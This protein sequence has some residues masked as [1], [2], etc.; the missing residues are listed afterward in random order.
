MPIQASLILVILLSCTYYLPLRLK[1]GLKALWNTVLGFTI[2]TGGGVGI[3]NELRVLKKKKY[4]V[5]YTK[6][7]L[8]FIF[9]R[10][11]KSFADLLLELEPI[12]DTTQKSTSSPTVKRHGLHT[13]A[14]SRLGM[15][16][17]VET[18]I[19]F[20]PAETAIIFLSLGFSCGPAVHYGPHT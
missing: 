6:A 5:N 13:F 20:L 16:L 19:R 18:L 12:P 4:S 10:L 2:D 8:C 11:K 15:A 3:V 7:P 9:Q 17:F 1:I 14:T